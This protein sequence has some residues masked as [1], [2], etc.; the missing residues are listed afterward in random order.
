MQRVLAITEGTKNNYEGGPATIASPGNPRTPAEQ[1]T[2]REREHIEAKFRGGRDGEATTPG[3][4]NTTRTNKT[5]KGRAQKDT[6]RLTNVLV[7]MCDGGSAAAFHG[8][9]PSCAKTL[10]HLLAVSLR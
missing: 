3:R 2:P 5:N 10:G 8:M 7:A 1:T 4:A 6:C 9:L